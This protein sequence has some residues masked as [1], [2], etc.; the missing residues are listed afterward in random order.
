V[1]ALLTTPLA[2]WVDGGEWVGKGA[3]A[4]LVPTSSS[5]FWRTSWYSFSGLPKAC[6][7][8]VRPQRLLRVLPA[9]RSPG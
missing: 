9:E 4:S 3:A 1:G 2:I 7:R 5:V 8:A 6:A